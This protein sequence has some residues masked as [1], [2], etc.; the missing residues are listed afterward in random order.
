MTK[1]EHMTKR[2]QKK[3]DT[4]EKLLIA[5]SSCFAEKGYSA[6]SVS[7]IVARA[8]MSQGS[9]YV[10]FSDKEDLFKSM[11]EEEHRQGAEK[12]RRASCTAPFLNGMISLMADCIVDVGFPID[13]RLWTEILAVAAR[14]DS[15]RAA[16]ISSDREMRKVFTQ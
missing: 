7:D 8:G 4:K 9:L 6:C 14:D 5:A 13:H 16:F 15:M 1:R 2:E 12:A 10:H 3:K 11:I